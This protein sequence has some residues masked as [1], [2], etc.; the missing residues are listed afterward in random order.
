[1]QVAVRVEQEVVVLVPDAIAPVLVLPVVHQINVPTLVIPA[2]L[3]LTAIGHQN[4]AQY[5]IRVPFLVMLLVLCTA[6][7]L[8]ST[9]HSN[10]ILTVR[11]LR[12]YH[13]AHSG[14]NVGHPNLKAR[15]IQICAHPDIPPELTTAGAI[16]S[17][18]SH[19]NARDAPPV[20]VIPVAA[21][22]FYAHM[23]I[24]KMIMR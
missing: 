17:W 21:A 10:Q 5:Q 4:V 2:V 16:W 13:L 18:C 7:L 9:I 14:T 24:R 3:A 11:N 22:E 20:H 19:R 8:G 6:V 23:T 12:H 15:L 1:V